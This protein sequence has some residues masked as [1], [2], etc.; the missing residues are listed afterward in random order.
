MDNK[1]DPS[2]LSAQARVTKAQGQ[3]KSKGQDNEALRK[4][5]RD[6][7]AIFVQSLFKEMRSTVPEGGLFKKGMAESTFVE[8]LDAEVAKTAVQ[9][10][11]YGIADALYRQLLGD[12]EG[13]E[14]KAVPK[15][16]VPTTKGINDSE[17]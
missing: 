9:K 14:G 10:Q 1:I 11:G 12:L 17:G 5:S 3:A 16:T 4:L 7:E 13:S 15:E 8:M 2:M 6:F